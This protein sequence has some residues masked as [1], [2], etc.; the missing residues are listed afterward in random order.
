MSLLP[1]PW[2]GPKPKS[3]KQPN[4]MINLR[5]FRK[6]LVHGYRRQPYPYEL[7][8]GKPTQIPYYEI[9]GRGPPPMDIPTNPGDFYIDQ[10]TPMVLYVCNNDGWR[11]W[12]EQPGDPDSNGALLALHPIIADRYLG[13]TSLARRI[14]WYT[15][16]ALKA[17]GILV[18]CP[19]RLVACQESIDGV[20]FQN[21]QYKSEEPH[22]PSTC[23]ASQ[24]RFTQ[25]SSISKPPL[26]PP[27]KKR[28]LEPGRD[29][30]IEMCQA[31]DKQLSALKS[32]RQ[33]MEA[34]LAEI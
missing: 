33:K 15:K 31:K 20:Q 23:V 32:L 8:P 27:S 26:G 11:V 30:T 16:D 21:T 18:Q 1:S 17:A 2:A 29:S 4:L 22:T 6:Q 24:R 19:M 3:K 34:V 13:K 12:G 7:L 14:S 25:P 9:F 10:A 28:K 5:T